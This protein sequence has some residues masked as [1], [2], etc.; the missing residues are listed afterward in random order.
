[1][2]SYERLFE[3]M[4]TKNISSYRLFKNGFSQTTY[5]NMKKGLS[6]STNTIDLLCKLLDCEVSDIME[7]LPDN[8]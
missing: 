4:K 2:I 7:Y 5:Y 6:V 1:M 3:T 8:D